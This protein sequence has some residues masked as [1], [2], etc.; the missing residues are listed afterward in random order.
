MSNYPKA[1]CYECGTYFQTTE[2]TL[3]IIR[4]TSAY[5]DIEEYVCGACELSLYTEYAK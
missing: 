3:S 4:L 2:D 5:V 1:S